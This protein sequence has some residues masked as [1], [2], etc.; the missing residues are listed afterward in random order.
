MSKLTKSYYLNADVAFLAKDLLGKMLVTNI[1]GQLTGGI[2]T[3]TEAYLGSADKA[4]HA[5]NNRKTA[6][7]QTMFQ[8][9]GIAYVYLCYGLHH[10]LNIVTSAINNPNTILIRSIHPISG[11]DIMEQRR[12]KK[13]LDKNFSTGP[14]S[15]SK[16][17]GVTTSLNAKSLDSDEIWVEDINFTLPESF[18]ETSKR[19]GIEYAQEHAELLLRFRI[20]RFYQ[21]LQTYPLHKQD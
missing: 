20:S 18:I 6:R 9:G 19:I 14:G 5:Y 21:L 1:N 12:N 13:I 2:I 17:L 4:S 3:E 10:L 7:T 16:A 8:E 11:I 15:V